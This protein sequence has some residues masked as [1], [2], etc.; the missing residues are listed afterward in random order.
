MDPTFETL[1]FAARRA[2]NTMTML[3]G[4]NPAS[5]SRHLRI[6]EVNH[7]AIKSG[8]NVC[9]FIIYERLEIPDMTWEAIRAIKK[10]GIKIFIV[11]NSKLS[12]EEA[13]KI[14][15]FADISMLRRNVGKDFGGYKDAFLYL[16]NRGDL[17]KLN[18]LVFANDSVVF[19]KQSIKPIFEK[20]INLP[21]A[22]VGYSHVQEVHY[23]IQ[24]FLFSCNNK[25]SN[26]KLFIKFWQD[27]LPLGRRRYMIRMGE[28]GLTKAVLK[29]GRSIAILNTIS[30]LMQIKEQSIL[31]LQG[32][33]YSLPTTP[34]HK[35]DLIDNFNKLV[36]TYHFTLGHMMKDVRAENNGKIYLDLKKEDIE[37]RKVILN[38]FIFELTRL[39]STRNNTHW[40]TFIFI[41]LG[42]PVVIKRDI[43]YRAGYDYDYCNYLLKK[44]FKQE[45][46]AI[47]PMLKSPS[48]SHF[49]GIK[50]IMFQDGII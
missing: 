16:H 11:L 50:R 35:I 41:E 7:G 36:E 47:V 15:K 14:K 32:I 4:L 33:V 8:D 21:N 48:S 27:Y 18:R 38:K 24:S 37:Y 25:L 43:L 2:D 23:H 34:L 19:P 6:K 12:D 5:Y 29:S 22:F 45:Y 39:L 30:D 42:L 13:S 17:K 31:K 44:H 40:N 49:K 1:L 20:L 28:V 26:D 3:H 10:M 9:I 46:E